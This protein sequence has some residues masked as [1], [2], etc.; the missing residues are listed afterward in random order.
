MA[1][2]PISTAPRGRSPTSRPSCRDTSRVADNFDEMMD[3]DGR[4]REHWRPFLRMLAEL[5]PEEIDRR[6]AAAD[7]HLR[8]SGVFYRVYEDPA[9][10]VR[11]WPL[12]HIPLLIDAKE[13]QALKAGLIQRAELLEAILKDVY[14]P[15]DLVRDGR[16][17]AAVIAGNPEFLRPLVGAAPAGGAHLRF[18]AVDVGRSPEGRWW[19]LGDRTPGAV[20][21]RLRAGEPDRA[22]ARDAGHLSRAARRARWRRSFRRSRRSCPSLNRQ[23]DSRVCVLTPG[24]AERNLFR[25][26]LSRALSRLPAG[27]RRGPHRPRGRRLHPHGVRPQAR[28]GAAA[29]A[30]RRFRRPARTERALAAGRARPG[31]GG[32]RRHGGDRQCAR[33][34][35]WS[36]RARC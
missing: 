28:R 21:R 32:A 33:R 11:P 3:R 4:V 23:D 36:K 5:G 30:R 14:G 34:R 20:R 24:P 12:S 13:W 35:A 9:G 19:V 25:A 31:A 1:R 29:P 7:R 18:Y 26:R 22:V 2:W 15:A 27:R 16:L 17:P 6:F 10:A 8:D